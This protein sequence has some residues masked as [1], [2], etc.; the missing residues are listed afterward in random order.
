MNL[1]ASV[2]R[3][4][5]TYMHMGEGAPLADLEARAEAAEHRLSVLEQTMRSPPGPAVDL[6]TLYN[7][8]AALAAAKQEQEAGESERM[9]VC[10]ILARMCLKIV[11]QGDL[12]CSELT[13]SATQNGG[14]ERAFSGL[15]AADGTEREAEV[16]DRA[17]EASGPGRGRKLA[18]LTSTPDSK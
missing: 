14:C 11:M 15:P 18:R 16:P 10:A 1:R 2:I 4:Y 3:K 8:R 7:I 5:H 13:P 6:Q 17:S 9:K 12:A